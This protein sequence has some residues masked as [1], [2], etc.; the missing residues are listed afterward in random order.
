[1]FVSSDQALQQTIE[2]HLKITLDSQPAGVFD[3][4][5]VPGDPYRYNVLVYGNSNMPGGQH[6]IVISAETISVIE[7]DY[8]VY[9]FVF[10]TY[11]A[12]TS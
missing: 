10:H 12:S 9:S 11:A 3:F 7:F 8:A 4:V 1:L 5:P 2:T 6:T